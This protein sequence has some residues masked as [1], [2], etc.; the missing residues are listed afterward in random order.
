MSDA[1]YD[2]LADELKDLD[3]KNA[4]LKRVGAPIKDNRL[5]KVKH[6]IAMGSQSKVNTQAEF[7]AWVKKTGA[8]KFAIQE[9]LDGLSVELIYE[10]GVLT[11]AVTRGDGEIGE[12]VTHN[13]KHM[14]NVHEELNDF[15]GSLRGEIIFQ[16]SAFKKLVA[17]SGDYSNPRNAAAGLTRRKD[18]HAATSSMLVLYYDVTTTKLNF[19]KEHHKIRFL[20]QEYQLSCVP[21]K[22]VGLDNAIK[23]YAHYQDEAREKLNY[24]IDGLVIKVNDLVL[25]ESLGETDGRPKGQIAWKFA[26]EMRR[27]T[28]EDISWEVGL[29]GRITPVGILKPVQV[30]GV[31]IERVSMHNVSQMK[32][33]GVWI[34]AEVLISRANDVIPY[35]NEVTKPKQGGFTHPDKCPS[36]KQPTKFEGEYLTCPNGTCLAKIRGD[37]LKWVKVLDIEQAGEA[38]VDAAIQYALIKDPADLYTITEDKVAKL[39]GFGK[40]S[41]KVVVT[42]INKAKEMSLPKFMAALNIANCSLSTFTALYKAGFDTVAKLR[43]AAEAELAKIPGV[44]NTT[45]EDVVSGVTSKHDVM[46]K[47]LKNG[48]TIKQPIVGKLTGK[49]FCFTGEICIKRPDAFKLVESMGGEIKSSVSKGLDFL[50]QADPKSTST[51]ATKARSYG[52]KVIGEKEFLDMVEF[53]LTKLSKLS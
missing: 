26:A 5:K 41:A 1:E 10:N 9:K 13:V 17:T 39:P 37:I 19:T 33:L 35:L 7:E 18:T 49:S 53:S 21:T 47:L 32:K 28:L 38:F 48:V 43:A 8:D 52:T 40:N 29:S 27:T 4:T 2:A 50:V 34:G 15:T 16:K 44:G 25:Q 20:E 36:C 6:S 14:K 46:D 11:A 31:T 3:P 12:D 51:K 22:V 24:E 23:W 30:G 42:N 45:A